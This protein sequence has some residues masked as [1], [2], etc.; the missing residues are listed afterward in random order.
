MFLKRQWK[1]GMCHTTDLYS[2]E[3][4]PIKKNI[5]AG[6]EAKNREVVIHLLGF[7]AIL[8]SQN[9]RGIQQRTF[10]SQTLVVFNWNRLDMAQRFCC[11]LLDHSLTLGSL[12][13]ALA[14]FDWHTLV[15][16]V[17]YPSCFLLFSWDQQSSL[18]IS[19]SW[20]RQKCKKERGNTNP[21]E[22]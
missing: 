3:K 15:V 16:T 11:F 1:F 14:G 9:L 21:L 13:F 2:L 10:I 7:S 4:E 6:K 18:S 22:F 20:Q 5:H 12:D 19:F 17:S 8:Q